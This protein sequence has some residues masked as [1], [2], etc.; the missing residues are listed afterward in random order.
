MARWLI[1]NGVGRNRVI[2]ENRSMS[3][4]Q[5]AI[6]T[7]Q[8]L[9]EYYPKVSQIALI[10]SDYHMPVGVM[11]FEAQAALIAGETGQEQYTVVSNA[12]Y[13][14]PTGQFPLMWQAMALVELASTS[15]AG[16]DYYY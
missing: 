16:V 7:Y 9:Q 2:A 11:L 4:A 10:T 3:T 1:D 14:A 13:F 15:R 8:I 5:N 6:Y 12:A